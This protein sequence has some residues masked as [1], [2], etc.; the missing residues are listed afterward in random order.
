MEVVTKAKEKVRGKTVLL[1]SGGMDS[2]MINHLLKPHVLLYVAHGNAYM[3]HEIKSLIALRDAGAFLPKRLYARKIMSFLGDQERDDGIIPNRNI[4][5]ITYASYYGET[6]WLGSMKGDRSKDKDLPF[7]SLMSNLLRHTWSEQ[8]WTETRD[9][10]VSAPFKNST[11]AELVRRYLLNNG[12]IDHLFISRSCYSDT[13]RPCGWCKPCFRKYVALEYNNIP[14]KG[15]FEKDPR[16][17]PWLKEV[18]AD[19]RKK[20]YRDP[21]EDMQTLKVLCRG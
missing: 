8:H 15:Y 1:F 13:K 7:F 16:E 9:I 19:I 12:N 10:N 21:V 2:L 11:K 6:I 17:A 18:I 14:T 3:K 5:F 20:E 4:Y